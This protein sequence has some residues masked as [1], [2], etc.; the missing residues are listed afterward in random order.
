MLRRNPAR[1][2]P[3][4]P[5]AVGLGALYLALAA[6][7][8]VAESSPPS[9]A[10]PPS[11]AFGTILEVLHS[12]RCM[13]CHPTDDRPR[14]GD[15]QHEHLFQVVRGDDDRSTDDHSTDDRGGV[16]QQ[17]ATCHRDENNAYSQIPGA[18]H[19]SLAPR[20]MGWLGL[21]DEAIRRRLLDPEANG[22]RSVAEL[23]HHMSEDAL[24]LWAWQP[25]EGR[26]PPSVPLEEFRA[27]LQQ[28]LQ[29]ETGQSNPTPEESHR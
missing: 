5:L 20:S 18:P 7:P 15:D 4:L 12:P 3:D 28:W 1:R 23:V 29:E 13:N 10:A 27:A 2:R 14:Q 17:C 9:A 11:P 6:S 22:G 16:V 8:S 21:S 26:Q 24:V 19:W 25:G